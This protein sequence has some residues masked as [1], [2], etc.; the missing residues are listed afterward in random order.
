MKFNAASYQQELHT[1]MAQA[2]EDVIAP[3]S[4]PVVAAGRIFLI[5]SELVDFVDQMPIV[6]PLPR[7]EAFVLGSCHA[8][9]RILTVLDLGMA[10]GASAVS[11]KRKL[12]AFK[13]RDF[14]VSAA[15]ANDKEML[16]L[17]KFDFKSEFLGANAHY[18]IKLS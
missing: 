15:L 17:P 16:D 10:L 3:D 2:V 7:A 11:H 8:R 6:T 13:A 9:G 14:A 12:V 4:I 5:A 18:F 1:K